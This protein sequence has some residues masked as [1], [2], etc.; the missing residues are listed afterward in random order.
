[1]NPHASAQ[2]KIHKAA[3]WGD[4]TWAGVIP[5]EAAIRIMLWAIKLEDS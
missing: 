3:A 5:G 4:T 2:M 1:M